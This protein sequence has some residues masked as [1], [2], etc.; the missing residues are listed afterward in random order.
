MTDPALTLPLVAIKECKEDRR[1]WKNDKTYDSK[2]LNGQLK[3]T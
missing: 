3:V 1:D 2:A